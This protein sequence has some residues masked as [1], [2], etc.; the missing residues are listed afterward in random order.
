MKRPFLIITIPIVMGIVI[1]YYV[2]VN[3]R[4]LFLILIFMVIMYLLS[5]VFDTNDKICIIIIFFIL[6]IFITHIKANNSTLIKFIDNRVVLEGKIIEEKVEEGLGKYVVLVDNIFLENNQF[7]IKEKLMLTV[8]GDTRLNLGEKITFNGVLEEPRENT[9]PKMFNYKLYLL[10][11]NIY[12]TSKIRDYSI[13]KIEKQTLPWYDRAKFKFID[14]VETIFDIYLSKTNSLLMKS[15]VLGNY[16]YLNENVFEKY[17]NLGLSHL[18]AISGLHIGIISVF[19]IQIMAYI[20]FDR[21]LNYIITIS[22]IWFY[23][24]CVNYPSSVIRSNIIL[25]VYFCSQLLA[26]RYDI[27]NTLLFAMF[28]ILVWN[29]FWLFNVGFQLSFI[30]T[31]FIILLTPIIKDKFY[32]YKNDILSSFCG[33]L[34]AQIGSI[35]IVAYYFNILSLISI[36][37]NLIIVPLLSL[38]LVMG[39]ILILISSISG[40][41]ANT[42]GLILNFL[43]YLQDIFTK[44][45]YNLPL[46]SIRLPSPSITNIILYYFMVLCIFKI[47][48]MDIFNKEVEKTIFLYLVVF[49]VG[50][51]CFNILDNTLIINFVDVGQGDCM[52]IE[53]NN[54]VFLIDTGGSFFK[55]VGE[56][57][58]L[59]YLI[60]KGIFTVD[61]VFISHFDLDHCQGLTYLMD[62]IKIKR[63]YIGYENEE[64]F[65]FSNI[66][67]KCK[68]KNTPIVKL[69]V[70]DKYILDEN[71]YFETIS[72]DNNIIEREIDSENNKSL[73]LVLNNYNRKILF[74]GDIE[75]DVERYISNNIDYTIDFLKVPHHGS[76]TSSTP[77][78]I[79]TIKPKYAFIQVGKNNFGHPS[80]EVLN[81]YR[82]R[83][84]HVYRNDLDGHISLSMTKYDYLIEPYIVEKSSIIN[85]IIDNSDFIS[86]SI[87]YL[88]ICYVMIKKYT[89]EV[90]RLNQYDL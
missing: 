14:R 66:V 89:I 18:M 61:G 50:T 77:I 3:I 53:K 43:L 49:I 79:D 90:E 5:I 29:P 45:L 75:E 46:V 19:L 13:M 15:I 31:F 16:S 68:E 35:P 1:Y 54:K 6:G 82:D 59:P 23:G 78:F 20:G 74:T 64:N 9:N 85:L 37:A 84:I 70:G 57:I 69:T 4:F 67:M 62:N 63:V 30:V 60:K 12:T 80:E 55:N 7:K 48:K 34:A 27:L 22:I 33:I 28:I 17:G 87:I 41:I 32:P 25:T 38:C 21:K 11:H 56:D 36:F 10:S 65:L 76:A 26:E 44:W 42:I 86:F 72:P 58:V 71:T 2:N 8:I 24:Y 39:F 47:I 52:V 40:T 81:M 83:G 88:I 73:V 51:S